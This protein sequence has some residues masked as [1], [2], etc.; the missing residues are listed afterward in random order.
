MAIQ[1]PMDGSTNPHSRVSSAALGCRFFGVRSMG[2]SGAGSVANSTVF[3]CFER[4][5][6]RASSTGSSLRSSSSSSSGGAGVSLRTFF[7]GT[8]GRV[9]KNTGTSSSMSM[10]IASIHES[11]NSKSVIPSSD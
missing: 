9:D 1:R 6:L 8:S 2:T 10:D 7:A 5:V 3:A 4:A 11:L